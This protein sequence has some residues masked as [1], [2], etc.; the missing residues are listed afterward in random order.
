[1]V[2]NRVSKRKLL[3]NRSITALILGLLSL[4]VA[5]FL[6]PVVSAQSAEANDLSRALI[7]ERFYVSNSVKNRLKTDSAFAARNPDL[8]QKVKDTV[9]KFKSR[10]DARVAVIANDV[11]PAT[12]GGNTQRYGESV[13]DFIGSKPDALVMVNAQTSDYLLVSSKLSPSDRDKIINEVR[14]TFASKGIGA[15]IDETIDKALSKI[16]G[17]ATTGLITTI[18]IVAVIILLFIGIIVATITSTKKRWAQQVANLQQLANQVSDK[19]VGISDNISFL[20]DNIRHQADAEF[21]EATRNFSDANAK[22]RELEGATPVQLLLKG[23]DFNRQ[24]NL[25][26]AQFEQLRQSLTRIEQQVNR[27]LPGL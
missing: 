4:F 15:G 19:V 17:N 7:N 1:M 2:T 12:L 13:Y 25:T 9:N 8:E 27:Q 18:V 22:L 21:G 10:G 14:P 3:K 24:L 23:A 6:A 5:G 16:A 11:I 26:G 20:P